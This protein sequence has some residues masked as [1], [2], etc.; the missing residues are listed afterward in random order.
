MANG[1]SNERRSLCEESMLVIVNILKLSSLSLARKTLSVATTKDY[2]TPEH[3]N[4]IKKDVVIPPVRAFSNGRSLQERQQDESKRAQYPERGPNLSYVELPAVGQKEK[5][6]SSS[7][8]V[9]E[10]S[11]ADGRFSDYIKRFHQ[12][13]EDDLK[14][15]IVEGKAADYIKRFHEKNR[16]DAKH[17]SGRLSYPLPPP[18]HQVQ[19]NR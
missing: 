12:K 13:A 3:R 11:H 2:P 9:H 4:F 10:A 16:N 14:N 5:A 17:E 7:Y 8:V 1:K 15:A 18:P 6:S 19:K